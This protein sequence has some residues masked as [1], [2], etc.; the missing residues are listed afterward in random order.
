MAPH[1][2]HL[3]PLPKVL[4]P[5]FTGKDKRLWKAEGLVDGRTGARLDL[6]ARLQLP[7]EWLELRCSAASGLCDLGQVT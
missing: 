3:P 6:P 2:Y 5:K 1:T 7:P 4:V